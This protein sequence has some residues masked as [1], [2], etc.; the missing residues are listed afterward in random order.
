MVLLNLLLAVAWL[1]LTGQFT[2][3]NFIFGLIVAY[4]VLWLFWR[5][6]APAAGALEQPSYFRKVGQI[7]SFAL[8][9]IWELIVANVRVALDVLRPRMQFEPAVVAVPLQ[10]YSDAEAT[11][12]ANF[13]TLTPGT[14]SLDIVDAQ[15]QGARTLYVHAMHAGATQDAIDRFRAQVQKTIARRVEEVMRR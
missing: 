15:N 11:L 7:V 3:L 12:L 4:G 5:A 14:L 1:L 9:F 10:A 2:P 13:L 8:F 6:V